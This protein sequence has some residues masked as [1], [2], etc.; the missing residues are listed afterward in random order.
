MEVP[1]SLKFMEEVID[2]SQSQSSKIV[3]SVTQ[4]LAS[5]HHVQSFAS[6]YRTGTNATLQN[7]VDNMSIDEVDEDVLN[8]VDE[9]MN[10]MM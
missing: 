5:G 9:Q 7:I 1:S 3:G 2:D 4:D 6:N 10:T 8:V